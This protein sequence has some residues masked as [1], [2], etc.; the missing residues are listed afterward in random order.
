[1]ICQFSMEVEIEF[2]D[3]AVSI[4]WEEEKDGERVKASVDGACARNRTGD[5]GA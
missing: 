2:G 5:A 4:E 3:G 1:M